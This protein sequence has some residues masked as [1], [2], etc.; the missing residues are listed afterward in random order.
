[1]EG[2]DAF[3]DEDLRGRDGF[4][5]FGDAGVGAEVVDGALDG[6]GRRRGCGRVRRAGCARGSRGDRSFAGRGRRG[7]GGLGQL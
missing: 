3:Y 4:G 2:E 6:C 5:A 7:A 1:M